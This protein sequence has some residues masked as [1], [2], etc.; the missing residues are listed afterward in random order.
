MRNVIFEKKLLPLTLASLIAKTGEFAYEVLFAI[1][2]IELLS[3]NYLS[4]GAVYF[5]RFIPYLFFGPIGGW[6]ADVFPQKY[7]MLCSDALRLTITAVLYLAYESA[8]LNIYILVIC[9]MGLTVGRSLYQPSFRAYLPA[10][11]NKNNLSSGNSLLQVI[12]DIA[13]ILGPLSCS[14]IITL[15]DKSYVLLMLSTSYLASIL[16]LTFLSNQHTHTKAQFSFSVVFSDTKTTI[17]SMHNQSKVL[18]L[19][20]IGTSACVLFTASL[21]RFVLPASII[22][23]YGS[24]AL[25]G[26]IFSLMSCGTV[27]GSMCYT[28]LITNSNPVQLMRSWMVYGL[29]FLTVSI[30]LHFSLTSTMAIIFLLGFSGAIVDIS[31]VTNIQLLSTKGDIGKNYGIFSTITNTCEAV[32]GLIS[33]I[34]SLLVGGVSFSLIAILIAVAAKTVITKIKRV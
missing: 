3:S 26:Y 20:I 1:I 29:F 17:T 16:L 30:T 31:I 32:S 27:L 19:V 24:E 11:I 14:L 25:V 5:F 34:F 2:T 18:F 28:S 10:V 22:D 7:N 13:S 6:L 8:E 21:L 23:A 12:E 4:I 33:G 15:Y 9:S